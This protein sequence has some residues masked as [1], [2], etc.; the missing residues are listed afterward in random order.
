MNNN[1]KVTMPIWRD[2][3][4]PVDADNLNIMCEGINQNGTDLA[5]ISEAAAL[6][7]N[8]KFDKV[9]LDGNNLKFYAKEV[10]KYSITLP[11]GS[12]GNGTP[13]ADGREVELRKGSTHLEWRYVGDS[14]WTQLVSL[15]ELSG[16]DGQDGLPGQDGA[17][18]RDGI[19]P[20]IQIGTVT[21][22][23]HNQ[24]ATVTRRGTNEE[25]VFDFAI[26]KGAPNVGGGD[27][28]SVDLSDYQTKID[29]NLNTENKEIVA[30]INEVASDTSQNKEDIN[31]LKNNIKKIDILSEDPLDA[32]V[33]YFYIL[34]KMYLEDF[35][36]DDKELPTEKWAVF[37]S[38]ANITEETKADIFDSKLRL[39]VGSTNIL[40]TTILQATYKKQ[41]N[42]LSNTLKFKVY[43]T[44][45]NNH[46]NI[47]AISETIPSASVSSLRNVQ[48]RI[49]IIDIHNVKF[50]VVSNIGGDVQTI[51]GLTDIGLKQDILNN[52]GLINFNLN[53]NSENVEIDVNGDRKTST[54]IPSLFNSGYI[55]FRCLNNESN[56]TFF[57]DDLDFK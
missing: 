13:G 8:N 42:L 34:K 15:D 20:N 40:E 21:T 25:P 2:G 57:F 5:A 24:N 56:K 33:G 39:F 29:E 51:V 19:T 45:G 28:G 10:E 16:R 48:I 44:P 55:T 37:K 18:G 1:K 30:A 3:Q 4:T 14:N 50:D 26:P 7:N 27:G 22:L 47:I 54:T 32:E 6:L 11:T 52:G 35:N 31:L 23:E 38:G 12:G 43:L 46:D 9:T 17:P 36:E 53:F 49:K 41:I